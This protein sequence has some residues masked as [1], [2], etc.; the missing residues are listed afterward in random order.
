[1]EQWSFYP[2]ATDAEPRFTRPWKHWQRYGDILLN[3]DFGNSQHTDIAVLTELPAS[4]FTDP[5]PVNVLAV[6]RK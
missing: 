4:V 1:M 6:G 2:Q 3:D 5:A